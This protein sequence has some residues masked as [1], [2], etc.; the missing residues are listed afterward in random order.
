[1]IDHAGWEY[2]GMHAPCGDCSKEWC[3]RE[4]S[5]YALHLNVGPSWNSDE[6]LRC[7]V[8]DKWW[9]RFMH[10]P[11]VFLEMILEEEFREALETQRWTCPLDDKK[12]NPY[13]GRKSLSLIHI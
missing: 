8:F 2:P 9:R 3:A 10:G 1:M 4:P 13:E 12:V 5:L 6:G 11:T 7:A